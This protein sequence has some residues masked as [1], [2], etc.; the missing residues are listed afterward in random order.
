MKKNSPAS[1]AMNQYDFNTSTLNTIFI[2]VPDYYTGWGETYT[3]F[4]GE[5]NTFMY[6]WKEYDAGAHSDAT[7][8]YSGSNRAWAR[9]SLY[10]GTYTDGTSLQPSYQAPTNPLF[11]LIYQLPSAQIVDIDP[12]GLILLPTGSN[13]VT[14]KQGIVVRERMK[15]VLYGGSMWVNTLSTVSGIKLWDGMFNYPC[16]TILKIE[17]GNIDDTANW[18]I[19]GWAYD[20]YGQQRA[21]IAQSLFDPTADY[22]VTYEIQYGGSMMADQM[23]ISYPQGFRGIFNYALST[24]VDHENKIDNLDSLY[25]KRISEPWITLY[26][27]NGWVSYSQTGDSN[28]A[29][30]AF[31]KDNMGIVHVK[32]LI[33]NGTI[34]TTCAILPAGYRPKDQIIRTCVTGDNSVQRMDIDPAGNITAV[35]GSSGFVSLDGLSFRAGVDW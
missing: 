29:K 10:N 17:K 32:G 23:G 19:S 5:I 22:F 31:Y 1:S 26:L 8:T 24:L 16:K 14:L 15:P 9:M 18:Q 3:P 11:R 33:S 28:W 20:V 7:G 13:T 21:I 30:P 35:S 25:A 2:D 27:T 4:K 6:G 12:T 34:N